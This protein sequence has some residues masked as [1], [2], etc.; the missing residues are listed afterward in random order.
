MPAHVVIASCDPLPPFDPEHAPLA[1]ALAGFGIVSEVV[2]WDRA[3]FDWAATDLVII[4]STWDYHRRRE[5][6][7]Q[8]ADDVAR[9][10]PLWN[11]A[12]LVRWNSHK[13]YLE[14]LR[15]A[16]VPVVPTHWLNQGE[17]A[18]LSELFA[19]SSWKEAVAKPAVSVGAERALRFGRDERTRAEAHVAEILRTTDVMLQPYLESVERYGERSFV[20]LGG[21]FSHAVLRAPMLVH[22]RRGA[23][24]SSPV[25]ATRGEREVSE[26]VLGKLASPWLYARVDLAPG[27][28]GLPLLMEL[29]LIEPSLFLRHAPAAAARL[30]EEIK[31]RL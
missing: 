3:G 6:F 26:Q 15:S 5:A 12:S 17:P 4:R 21:S 14:E 9:Q 20:Y 1:E 10:T 18:D 22:S 7:V 23:P 25:A 2:P 19:D 11:P 8:W 31:R 13:R 29:E 16:G 24:E 27:Q 30:A 28:D